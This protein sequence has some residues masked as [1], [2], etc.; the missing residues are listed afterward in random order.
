M[1]QPWDAGDTESAGAVPNRVGSVVTVVAAAL[2]LVAS[3][4]PWLE[5]DL[6]LDVHATWNA[7]EEQDAGL[8]VVATLVVVG[9][10]V[11]AA[12]WLALSGQPKNATRG[13]H[14]AVGVVA[15]SAGV[16]AGLLALIRYGSVYDDLDSVRFFDAADV[17]SPGPGLL[18][19]MVGMLGLLGGGIVDVVTSR[20]TGTAARTT[21]TGWA[22]PTG[23]APPAATTAPPESTAPST[24]AG[25]AP[26][27]ADLPVAPQQP[28]QPVPQQ[29]PAEQVRA[30]AG[31]FPAAWHP[32]PMRRYEFRYWDGTR[33]TE[34]VSTGGRVGSDPI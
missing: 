2:V 7:W 19:A 34:H 20:R 18:L 4:L 6:G 8:S 12:V 24:P 21:T 15:I 10:G 22:T 13:T 9:A 31:Q 32:D 11:F 17:L 25:T 5:L 26:W 29:A 30:P 14:L 3:F 1:T 27:A 23:W 33:W 28:T 16:L